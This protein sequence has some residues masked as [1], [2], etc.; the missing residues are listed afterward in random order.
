MRKELLAKSIAH[1]AQRVP[2]ARRLPVLK[3]LAAGELALIARDHLRRLTPAER[4]RLA[5]LVRVGRGRRSRL[6]AAEQSELSGLLDKLEARR[7]AGETVDR[8]SPVPLPKRVL[9][10]PRASR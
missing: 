5:T 3:L 1:A 6:T 2:G 10:G 4:R 8:L 7:L 9:Y